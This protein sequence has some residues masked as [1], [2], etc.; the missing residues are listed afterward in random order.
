MSFFCPYDSG[1]GP[2]DSTSSPIDCGAYTASTLITA[3]THDHDTTSSLSP[4][5]THG[6]ESGTSIPTTA[7]RDS[8]PSTSE[9]ALDIL[10]YAV[11]GAVGGSV[12]IIVIILM[13]AIVSLLA[14]KSRGKSHEVESNKNIGLLTYNNALYDVGKE[15]DTYNTQIGSCIVLYIAWPILMY[16]IIWYQ[17]IL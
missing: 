3:S 10:P 2:T 1:S 12:V 9:G 6:Q 4:S 7:A 16:S 5:S 17:F 13:V 8:T 11:G 15:I 14:R